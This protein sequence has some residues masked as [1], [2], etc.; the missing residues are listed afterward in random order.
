M[1]EGDRVRDALLAEVYEE[2]HRRAAM[3]MRGQRGDHTLQT[4]A[5]INE[6]FV[7]LG[8]ADS[9]L[10]RDRTRFIATAS[11]AM[12]QVLIDHARRRKAEKRKPPGERVPLDRVLVQFEARAVDLVE[13]D[14]ALKRLE[15]RDPEMA[16][17]VELRFFGGMSVEDTAEHLG[18][19]KR[20]FERR[21]TF[22]RTW[23]HEEI[24]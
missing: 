17:A 12:R 18:M 24:S 16:R 19:S 7:K 9:S 20:T 10:W 5:L 1:A 21:W 6:A 3:Y 8:E 14:G 4:T 11:R 15:E 22:V 2:L 23:L 13:L